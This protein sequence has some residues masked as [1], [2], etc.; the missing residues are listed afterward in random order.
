MFIIDEF[1]HTTLKHWTD[2]FCLLAVVVVGSLSPLYIGPIFLETLNVDFSYRDF[3]DHG[4]FAIYSTA[5][6]T[7]ALYLLYKNRGLHTRGISLFFS[8]LFLLIIIF[9]LTSIVIFAA[10]VAAT[11]GNEIFSLNKEFV[12]VWTVR[13]YCSSVVITLMMNALDNAQ[14]D[15]D[16]FTGMRSEN[17]NKLRERFASN[18]GGNDE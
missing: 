13:I 18:I 15:L 9:L 11:V 3:I 4:E 1:R 10:V 2:A 16:T 7:P 6:L 8:L 5:L 17:Q 14:G 12:R